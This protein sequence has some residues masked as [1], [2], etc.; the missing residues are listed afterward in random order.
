MFKFFSLCVLQP[1]VLWYMCGWQRFL[2]HCVN[3]FF[4]HLA[5]SFAAQVVS[6]LA[7]H[8]QVLFPTLYH[9]PPTSSS[10]TGFLNLSVETSPGIQQSFHRP[11]KASY[12]GFIRVLKLELCISN[13]I[14][15]WLVVTTTWGTIFQHCIIRKVENHCPKG[16]FIS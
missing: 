5:V 3:F 2:P 12:L 11:P 8:C 15:L 10:S 14:I 9:A 1:L 7:L 16:R 4:T 13:E 6:L